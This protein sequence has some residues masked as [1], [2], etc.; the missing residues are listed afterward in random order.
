MKLITVKEASKLLDINDQTIR[1]WL[2]ENKLKNYEDQKGITLLDK[3]ECLRKKT[4]VIS[5]FGQ[6]GGIS[7]TS[8][9]ILLSDYFERKGYKILLIDLDQQANLSKTYFD[10]EELKQSYSLYDYI[11][12]KISLH[13]I[14]KPYNENIDLLPASIKL[15]TKDNLDTTV[16]LKYKEDFKEALKKYELVIC[17]CPPSLNFFSRLGITLS[18]YI[19]LP[20][21]PEPFCLDGLTDAFET[22]KMVLPLNKDFIDYRLL[23]SRYESKKTIIKE[24]NLSILKNDYQTVLFDNFLPNYV[25]IIERGVTR[26]NLFKT[27]NKMTDSLFALGQEVE[28]FIFENRPIKE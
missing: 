20:T 16:A 15:A 26:D 1:N 22:M 4:T 2:K 7:K 24:N 25:G 11:E 14:I 8:T 3:S 21:I 13:K 12:S 5:I 6:K 23:V 17:D 28:S 19:I 27:K 18:N 10:Y 9:S